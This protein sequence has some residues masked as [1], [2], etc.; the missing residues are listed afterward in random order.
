[1]PTLS[2]AID[3]LGSLLARRLGRVA[4]IA[5]GFGMTIAGLGMTATVVVPLGVVT[6]LLGVGVFL[7][8]TFAPDKGDGR[9]TRRLGF[10]A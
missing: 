7:G 5:I 10:G 9:V 6:G 4:T 2:D 3:W 1:M 8:G